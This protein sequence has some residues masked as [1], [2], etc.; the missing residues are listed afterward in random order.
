MARF[1]HAVEVQERR[2]DPGGARRAAR[3]GYADQ[4]HL[5]REFCALGGETPGALRDERGP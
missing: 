1:R 3:C 5:I 2:P 4:S